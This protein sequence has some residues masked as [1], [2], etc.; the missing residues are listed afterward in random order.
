MTLWYADVG[1]TEQFERLIYADNGSGKINTGDELFAALM[2]DNY[3]QIHGPEKTLAF[4]E[5]RL[6]VYPT[7]TTYHYLNVRELK[8]AGA[9][10]A[11][12]DAVAKADQVFQSEMLNYISPNQPLTNIAYN[13]LCNYAS[14][15]ILTDRLEAAERIINDQLKKVQFNYGE[16]AL[17]MANYYIYKGDMNSAM[18]EFSKFQLDGRGIYSLSSAFL[19]REPAASAE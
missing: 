3:R 5:S 15:L 17:T 13:S 12:D 10:S 1:D 7:A 18:T 19:L 4:I 9:G 2:V 11:Y 14:Y 16:M 6:K 8:L